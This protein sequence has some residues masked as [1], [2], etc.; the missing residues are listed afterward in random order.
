MQTSGSTA[1]TPGAEG[2]FQQPGPLTQPARAQLNG[3]VLGFI[4]HARARPAGVNMPAAEFLCRP[5]GAHYQALLDAYL[6]FEPN[7]VSKTGTLPATSPV[8]RPK[9][10]EYWIKSHRRLDHKF[11]LKHA[12]TLASVPSWWENLR[13][14]AGG[15]AD[16]SKASNWSCLD[17]GGGNGMVVVIAA[18]IFWREAIERAGELSSQ[19]SDWEAVVRDVAHGLRKVVKHRLPPIDAF[20]TNP[21]PRKAP[22]KTTS[23]APQTAKATAAKASRAGKKSHKSPETAITPPPSPPPGTPASS[24]RKAPDGED[25]EELG[26]DGGDDGA[27]RARPRRKVSAA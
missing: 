7:A 11:V 13:L 2:P 26:N 23:A 20:S 12:D 10:M 6:S 17:I 18:I 5:Y 21:K 25:D 27:G 16:Q 24:K 15:A 4:T 19:I 14:L 1:T 3:I 22:K 9:A 8:R